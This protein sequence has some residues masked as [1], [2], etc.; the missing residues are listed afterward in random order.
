MR[1][2]NSM[3]QNA[4]ML[5]SR[6]QRLQKATGGDLHLYVRHLISLACQANDRSGQ[7]CPQLERYHSPRW[8]WKHFTRSTLAP[9]VWKYTNTHCTH[10]LTLIITYTAQL[11]TP[12]PPL[13]SEKH[14]QPSFCLSGPAVATFATGYRCSWCQLTNHRRAGC[15]RSGSPAFCFS[16]LFFISLLM[17][18]KDADASVCRVAMNALDTWPYG[19][20]SRTCT[21]CGSGATVLLFARSVCPLCLHSLCILVGLP[22]ST[23]VLLVLFIVSVLT[24]LLS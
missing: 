17:C 8:P 23:L 24:I 11:G 18:F 21:T 2:G 7:M 5:K 22:V 9:G 16:A 3:V 1:L 12:W 14:T 13:C 15:C 6:A 19:R 4:C 20:L 10:T